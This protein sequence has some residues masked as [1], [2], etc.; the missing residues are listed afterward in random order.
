MPVL[1]DILG[2]AYELEYSKLLAQRPLRELARSRRLTAFWPQV[3]PDYRKGDGWLFVG[4]AVD[5]WGRD[6][7]SWGEPPSLGQGVRPKIRGIRGYSTGCDPGELWATSW[8]ESSRKA[9]FLGCVRWLNSDTRSWRKGWSKTLA[10]SNLY[11][12]APWSGGNP[13]EALREAQLEGCRRLLQLEVRKLRPS[14]VV[15]LAGSDWFLDFLD[16]SRRSAVRKAVLKPRTQPI[17]DSFL[18]APA[19]L[20]PHPSTARQD[21]VGHKMLGERI[22]RLLKSSHPHLLS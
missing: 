7:V 16:P 8:M 11:K 18:N 1:P 4:R 3:G 9:G 5:G 19:V 6:V 12:I 21:R 10:W 2:R 22:V 15:F 17:V 13:D 20:A 14:L